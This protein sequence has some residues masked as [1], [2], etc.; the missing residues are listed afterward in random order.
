MQKMTQT[1]IIISFLLILFGNSAFGRDEEVS[2]GKPG[3]GPGL[4]NPAS[5][6]PAGYVS[7]TSSSMPL[8]LQKK[9][10]KVDWD[11]NKDGEIDKQEL[12]YGR[13][14]GWAEPPKKKR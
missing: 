3:G 1:T 5:L 13:K 12:A 2:F 7:N 14:K 11:L 4:K 10:Q 8:H 6:R 9:A